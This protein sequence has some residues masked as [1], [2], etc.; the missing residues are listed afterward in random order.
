MRLLNKVLITFVYFFVLNLF[1]FS[2]NA[3][4]YDGGFGNSGVEVLPDGEDDNYGNQMPTETFTSG[5]YVYIKD[6]S[7][8]YL[9]EY[10]GN[11]DTVYVPSKL[12]GINVV[13]IYTE[14]FAFSPDIRKVVIPEG[15]ISIYDDAFRGCR[16]LEE[17]DVDVNNQ[18]YASEDGVLYSKDYKYLVV[19]PPGKNGVVNV[20]ENTIYVCDYSFFTCTNV[21]DINIP[22]SVEDLGLGCFYETDSLENINISPYNKYYV[23]EDGVVYNK[24]KTTLVKCV[25]TK[26]TSVTIPNTVVNIAKFAFY[27]CNELKGPLKLPDNL[28]FIGEYAF[29]NCES[30]DTDLEFPDTL[31]TIEQR[32]FYGCKSL[33]SIKLNEGLETIPNFCFAYCESLQDIVIPDSVETIDENAFF[34]CINVRSLDLG[35]GIQTISNWAFDYLLSLEGDLIIPDSVLSIG[36]AAF[37]NCNSL[38]GYIIIGD[39]VKRVGESSFYRAENVKG[40]IFKGDLPY[41]TENSFLKPDVKYYYLSDKNGFEEALDGKDIS[42][43]NLKPIVNYIIDDEVYKSVMLDSY[44]LSVS[45]FEELQ[46]DGYEFEGWY[47]DRAFNEK[48]DFSD[49]IMKDTNL[50]AKYTSRNTIL[51]SKDETII[52]KGKSEQIEFTYDLEEGLT[53]NDIAWKS[54]DENVVKVDSNGKITAIDKGEALVTAT[55]KNYTATM[56]VIVWKD[57]NK[58]NIENETLSLVIDDTYK[59][60]Y[61]YHLLNDATQDDIVWSS[62]NEDVVTVDNHGN[63][64]AI[65][66]G[67]ATITASYQDASDSIEVT[68]LK[69]NSLDIQVTELV[70]QVGNTLDITYGYY[71]NDGATSDDI[72]W[73]SSNTNVAR[74]ENGRVIAK[75]DGDTTITAKYKDVSAS[76][77]V[78][79]VKP[80]EIEFYDDILELDLNQ[81]GYEFLY[82]WYSYNNTQEDFVW[83]SANEDVATVENGILNIKSVGET[84]ITVRCGQASDTIILK[85]TLPDTLEFNS[86]YEIIRFK[87]NEEINLDISY[88]FKDGSQ[89]DDIEYI[90]DNLSVIKVENNK[91]IQKGIGKANITAKYKDLED[92]ISIEIIDEDHISFKDIGYI[93]NI[94]DELDLSY[95]YYIYGEEDPKIE[96][97][98][99]NEDIV[100]VDSNGHLIAL[101]QGEVSITA[102]YKDISASIEVFVSDGSYIIGDVNQDKAVNSIDASMVID[103]YTNNSNDV[104]L[105]ILA[106]VNKD[107]AVNSL[108]SSLII[109]MYKNN[110]M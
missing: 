49:I 37:F 68:V 14:T 48:Y 94:N 8:L 106:D 75:L 29:F 57:E 82:K 52:E 88:Y 71:F 59:L 60:N 38:D 74:V 77:E 4:T 110:N 40:F 31:D 67:V 72:I 22:E 63:V 85:V 28:K 36:D 69:K 53:V 97:K 39:N 6:T 86:D 5:D 11:E 2:I 61:T 41:I 107:G 18:V 50:Y 33:R 62:S 91:L 70:L 105:R 58:I 73:T 98:S 102:S 34:Y 51:F 56:K 19:C 100:Y 32:A 25:D 9:V 16:K 80:D 89:Q 3:Q 30:L 21:T 66:D 47:Y 44:G 65:S 99:S 83:S 87:Q 104:L 46:K 101:A 1:L 20:N 17:I 81:S 35:E 79:V 42:V 23:E 13:G 90:S 27:E 92:T 108:D 12:D 78:H 45:E 96:F 24:A 55:C 7:G 76:V 64:I 26:D 43:Y 93:L 10:H 15:I 54:S 84:I 95:D 103:L 109:D